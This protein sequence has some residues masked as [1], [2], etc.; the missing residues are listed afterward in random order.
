MEVGKISEGI[1]ATIDLLKQVKVGVANLE[2]DG[3]ILLTVY[4][5]LQILKDACVKAENGITPTVEEPK[6]VQVGNM[7]F[8]PEE[9]ENKKEGAE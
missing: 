9:T 8:V 2:G 5:N 1:Q 3:L 7:R 4:K 6:D